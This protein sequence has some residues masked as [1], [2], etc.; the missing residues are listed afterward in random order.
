MSRARS[1]NVN[2]EK[3]NVA[4]NTWTRIVW[5]VTGSSRC[6]VLPTSWLRPTAPPYD[7]RPRRRTRDEDVLLVGPTEP[8][9]SHRWC[10][11][12]SAGIDLFTVE[13]LHRHAGL[14]GLAVPV[15]SIGLRMHALVLTPCRD[16][17]CLHCETGDSVVVEVFPG[18]GVKHRDYRVS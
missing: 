12:R 13:E 5:P 6:I 8:V 14:G 10:P 7:H 3:G 16:Q 2:R 17:P 9:V 4:T 11:V 1:T 18:G 15:P